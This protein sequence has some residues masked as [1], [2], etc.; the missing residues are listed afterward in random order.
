[1]LVVEV[2]SMDTLQ[3][4]SGNAKNKQKGQIIIA[5]DLQHST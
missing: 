5:C 1:M 4:P 2:L 3:L